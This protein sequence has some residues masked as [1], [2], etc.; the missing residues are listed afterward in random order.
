M[1]VLEMTRVGRHPQGDRRADAWRD[2]DETAMARQF[3]RVRCA[4]LPV[5]RWVARR[6]IVSRHPAMLDRIERLAAS[7]RAHRGAV[8]TLHFVG[9]DSL[10]AGLSAR[11]FEITRLP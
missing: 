3:E 11:G 9:P 6:L 5:G 4:V 7:E 2:G 1:N 10:L 8:G